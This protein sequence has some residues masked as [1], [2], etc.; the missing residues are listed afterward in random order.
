M[1]TVDC[2][3]NW[4]HVGEYVDV[5]V[6]N[7]EKKIRKVLGKFLFPTTADWYV[8]VQP[9]NLKRKNCQEEN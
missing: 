8:N 5:D 4:K 1:G 2:F 3:N 7:G 9:E 6:Q